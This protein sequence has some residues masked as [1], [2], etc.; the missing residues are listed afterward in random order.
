MYGSYT[1]QDKADLSGLLLKYG[2][3]TFEHAKAYQGFTEIELDEPQRT[4]DPRFIA[5]LNKVRDGDFSAIP[6]F[7]K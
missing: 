7:Q 4:K 2:T 1:D 5:L 3:L 6:E